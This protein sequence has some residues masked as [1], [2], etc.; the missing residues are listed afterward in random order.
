[1]AGSAKAAG[2]T[3]YLMSGK[4]TLTTARSRIMLT[5]I[6]VS[7][8]GHFYESVCQSEERLKLRGCTYKY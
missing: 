4:S 7:V 6:D 1:M 5:A 8:S 3:E 2:T